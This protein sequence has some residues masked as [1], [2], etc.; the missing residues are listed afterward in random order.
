MEPKSEQARSTANSGLLIEDLRPDA[1]RLSPVEFQNRYG[2]AFL[3]L[4]SA[5]F[6][7]P[8][9]A[10]STEVLLLDLGEEVGERTAGVSVRVMPVRAAKNSLTHLITVGRASKND[11]TIGD[12]SVSRFHAFFKRSPS[13]GFQLQDAGSSNGTIVNEA[14]VCTK[15]AGPPAGVNSGDNIRFG[16]VEATFLEANALRSYVV[17]FGD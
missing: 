14:S 3:L 10:T 15:E 11:V 16:Q 1:V 6:K 5:G 2:D 4:S 13:G 12:I 7:Q 8:K 17:K 9:S